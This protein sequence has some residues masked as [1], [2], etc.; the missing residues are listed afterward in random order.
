MLFRLKN[1]TETFQRATNALLSSVK[2]QSALIY[3]CDIVVFSKNSDILIAQLQQVIT[4]LQDR[5]LTLKLKKCSFFKE[6]VNHLGQVTQLRRLELS[7]AITVAVRVLT[8][9][10]SHSELRPFLG[11]WNVLCRFIPNDPEWKHNWIE[12]YK[13]SKTRHIP[14]SRRQKRTQ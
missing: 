9:L 10:L 6:M 12:D 14:L 11:F 7:K 1:A 4:L 13:K 5:A 8:D 2:W 3:L